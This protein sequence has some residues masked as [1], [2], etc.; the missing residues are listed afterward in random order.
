MIDRNPL[1]RPSINEVEK[2]FSLNRSRN[3]STAG[4]NTSK[5]TD[6]KQFEVRGL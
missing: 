1:K 4:S 6:E 3:K 2:T 5:D